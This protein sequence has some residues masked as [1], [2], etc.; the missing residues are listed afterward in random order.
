MDKG[1][2]ALRARGMSPWS[3]MGLDMKASEEERKAKSH[4]CFLRRNVLFAIRDLIT[5]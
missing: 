4:E 5:L 1:V 2:E 3:D